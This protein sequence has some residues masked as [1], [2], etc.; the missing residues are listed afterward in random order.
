MIEKT[1]WSALLLTAVLVWSD[2][3]LF[4][5]HAQTQPGK[6]LSPDEERIIQKAK[7]EVLKELRESDFLKEQ[8]QLG[9]QEYVK[10]QQEAQVAAKLKQ[11]RIANEMA[12]NVRPVS[13]TRDHIYGNSNAPISLIEYSDFECP[14][15]K[16]FHPTAKAIVKA[17]GGKVNW[18]YR[19]FPLS[20]H[21]PGAQ[22]QAE[23]AECANEFGGNEAFW[24]YTDSIY[25]RTTSNGKGFPLSELVPL[26]KEIGLDENRFT[27]CL[28]SSK[29]AARVKEDLDEGA[30]IGITGTPANILFHHETGTAV[31]KTG[32]Q[33]LES[34]KPDIERMLKE[35]TSK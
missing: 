2:T 32:A 15:C 26:A 29:Y 33:P 19:H 28:E 3:N 24:K 31:V 27:R 16:S 34:F 9:I 35:T 1:Y 22:K 6:G 10:K 13:V 30:K 4:Q 5:V 7:E 21:N 23:A 11:V 17:Y 20:F 18:V 12:Q 8:I 25:E 14:F